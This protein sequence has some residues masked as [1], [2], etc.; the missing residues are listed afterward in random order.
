MR[1]LI[2][3]LILSS[4]SSGQDLNRMLSRL[5]SLMHR[6]NQ[7]LEL[8]NLSQ[9]S[10]EQQI[11]AISESRNK[12]RPVGEE[13]QKQLS[14]AHQKSQDLARLDEQISALQRDLAGLKEKL[15]PKIESRIRLLEKHSGTAG[16]ELQNLN[17]RLLQCTPDL[18][19]FQ[20]DPLR[21]GRFMQMVS[22]DS[23]QIAARKDYLH[24][25]LRETEERLQTV[26]RQLEVLQKQQRLQQKSRDFLE[27]IQSQNMPVNIDQRSSSASGIESNGG[28]DSPLGG[29]QEK[30]SNVSL[31]NR[32][33]GNPADFK[34]TEIPGETGYIE[35]L[36]KL[37]KHLE[38]YRRELDKALRPAEPAK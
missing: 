3:L 29:W 36:E 38:K 22:H 1:I 6:E 19:P 34:T 24:Y 25:A 11:T 7:L 32:Q 35:F 30:S 37:K 9:A 23:V 21:A 13:K 8:R 26:D 12:R 27:D 18:T 16:D 28:F 4:A 33:L 31:L 20:H 14:Q 17:L 10:L 2:A 5:D 15:Y